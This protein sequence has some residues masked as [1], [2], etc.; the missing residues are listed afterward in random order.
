MINTVK[1]VA[2]LKPEQV[3]FHML[4]VLKDTAL[5]EMYLRGEYTPMTREEYVTAIAKALEYL[6]KETVI[7]RI[8]GDA[9]AADLLAPEWSRKKLTVIDEIDKL[10]F[11][12]QKYQ[13]IGFNER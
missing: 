6:P 13:G 7:G 1:E 3:K 11:E 2:K 12:T 5:G 4:Y 8:T 10:L 9:P